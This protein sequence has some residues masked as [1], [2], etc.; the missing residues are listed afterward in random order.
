MRQGGMKV[1]VRPEAY[2][3]FEQ[4][5]FFAPDSLAVRTTGEPMALAEEVR[6][7]IWAVDK[8]EPVT[9]IMPLQQLVD[10]SVSATRLQTLLLSGFGGMALL[11]AS[12]GIYAV[13]SFAVTQRTQ[14]FG[15]RIAMGA[16]PAD[17]LGMVV[18]HGVRLF[19]IGLTIG[20]AAALALSRLLKHLLFGVSA[21]DPLSY[22]AVIALLAAVTLLACWLPARRAM[23]VE[24]TVALRCE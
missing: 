3:S 1:P 7:Q 17:V 23:R 21:G 5:A 13:L 6:R 19:V 4:A 16:S 12:L 2:F 22:A 15:V 18:A 14:E 24:P 20:L 8:E 9:A 11:L 10:E